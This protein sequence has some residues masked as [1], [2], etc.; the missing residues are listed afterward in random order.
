MGSVR[1]HDST[2]G[3]NLDGADQ[4][5]AVEFHVPT[6]PTI[7]VDR[8]R[9]RACLDR[10]A[11]LPLTLV[12]APA[13]T[14]KTTLVASWVAQREATH[15]AAWVTFEVGDHD[16]GEFWP[17]VLE[18]LQWHGIDVGDSDF[19]TASDPG[20]RHRL[21]TLAASLAKL[22]HPLTLVLDGY[23]FM[24]AEVSS[25]LDFVLRHSDHRLHVVIVT[26]VDP[27][28]PLHRYRLSD[29]MAEIR[30][31]ELAFT[32]A[33][34]AALLEA[35][36]LRLSPGS[37]AALA[38][39][40]Q[41]WAAGLRFAIM[42][43]TRSENPDQAVRQLAGD[44]GNIAEYL[45]AEVLQA[46]RAE[47]RDVLL[48][49]SVVD[50][51]QPGLIEEIGGPSAGRTLAW[52]AHS[53]AF[54]GEIPGH[55]G[56]YRYHALFRELLRAELAYESPGQRAHLHRKAASWLA[57][58]GYL[59]AAVDC[60]AAVEAWIEASGFVV[61]NL[62]IGELL[63]GHD[64]EGLTKTLSQM[65]DDV[66]DPAASVV[67]AALALAGHNTV[68]CREE[69][70]QAR[71]GVTTAS[72]KRDRAARLAAHVVE[73][74]MACFIEAPHA[75]KEIAA[76]ADRDL[77]AQDRRRLLAHP[78][79]TALVQASRGIA[80][81]RNGEVG[82]AMDALAAGARAAEAPG[83]EALLSDCLGY[84]ALIASLQGRL[85]KARDWA[86][87]SIALAEHTGVPAEDRSPAG[88]I[89]LAWVST[90]QYD[91]HAGRTHLEAASRSTTLHSDPVSLVMSGLVQARLHRAG[92]DTNRA[93]AAIEKAKAHASRDGSWL[94]DRLKIEAAALEIVHGEPEAAVRVVQGLTDPNDVM[95]SLVLAQ[96]HVAQGNWV[97]VENVLPDILGRGTR[98]PLQTLIG[99]RLLAVAHELNRGKVSRA[100]VALDRSL[101]LAATE[102]LR[103]PFREAP[104]VVRKLLESDTEL[105]DRNRWLG[106]VTP[107][108]HP[109]IP[110]PRS[111]S[112]TRI[113]STPRG[114][115]NSPGEQII[116]P[117]TARELEVLDQ[118]SQLLTTE[119]VATA[120][121]VSVN[122][123][124]TH[125]RNILRKLAV[126]RRNEAVR[127]A[128]GLG[129]IAS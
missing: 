33:E 75:A 41:G 50:V 122:T 126:S 99:G 29:M 103:R 102:K 111:S 119:E 112:T 44:S 93:I 13:G 36:G 73:S 97:A 105:A 53:N 55:P 128:R 110:E 37:V 60:A 47:V 23:E 5:T 65:P 9:L 8:P 76:V 127:R 69:L 115:A 59:A 2:G 92:G 17:H 57:R 72:S 87:R 88:Q 15:H 20:D 74:V 6:S 121:F 43:L 101:R 45:L 123:V 68:R 28:L 104:A 26:R 113:P 48:C 19:M 27:V 109:T 30:M 66:S 90:E 10:G 124:R 80:L 39:R 117:L 114:G 118:L 64:P 106:S 42:F 34:V 100:R 22:P 84:L 3:T 129:L 32:P 94:V 70:N 77:D 63:L 85:Q 81:L 71:P 12:S 82:A 7:Y 107:H 108:Q 38:T 16:A 120:L 91:L 54:V 58:H 31:A 49:T 1:E 78:E 25:G 98:A 79:L 67:R 11:E 56:W 35:A 24:S 40:T 62:A 52:L 83:S 116:E 125:V 14:G 18:C 96:A 61:D 21:T 86:A 51:L 46:Q 4:L 89:A 95:S